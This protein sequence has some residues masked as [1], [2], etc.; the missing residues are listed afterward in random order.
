MPNGRYSTFAWQCNHLVAELSDA[1]VTTV[2]LLTLLTSVGRGDILEVDVSRGIQ[3]AGVRQGKRVARP[4]LFQAPLFMS[5]IT[6]A[7][8]SN[9]SAT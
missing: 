1:T 8:S 2:V 9:S 7:G 6:K 5:A 3:E 4:V